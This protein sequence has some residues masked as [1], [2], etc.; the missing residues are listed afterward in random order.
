MRLENKVVLLTG[1]SRGMGRAIALG[2]A[3]EGADLALVARNQTL[4]EQVAGEIRALGR[5]A[6]VFPGDVSDPGRVKEIVEEVRA[7]FGRIDI[8]VNNAGVLDNEPIAGHRDEVWNRVMGINLFAP[9]YFVREVIGEMMER[10]SG[11]ILIMAST[12]AKIPIGPNRAAY[13]ASKHGVLGLIR[14]VALEAAP[15]NVT[16]N[17]ICPGAVLTDMVRDSI[18]LMARDLGKSE[19]EMERVWRDRNPQK[20]LLEPEEV[21]PQALLLISDEA[22]GITGQ[23][24]NIN[25][26]SM[27][28]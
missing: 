27:M 14:E 20:R 4:L 17:G 26:G 16:V 13:V 5:K 28:V 24:V 21:V 25:G 10:R 18:R 11:R 1:A 22:A 3:R 9:F 2:C 23:T 6:A 19:E 12:S 7:E 15:F 8:L